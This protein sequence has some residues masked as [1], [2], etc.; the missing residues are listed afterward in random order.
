MK[1]N[2]DISAFLTLIPFEND[3]LIS[4]IN[5]IIPS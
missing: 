3:H 4:A 2:A 5:G 1:K